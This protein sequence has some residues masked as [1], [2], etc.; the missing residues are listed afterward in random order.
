MLYVIKFKL[1]HYCFWT[2]LLCYMLTGSDLFAIN[3]VLENPCRYEDQEVEV[4]GF[5]YQS[6]AGDL[7]LRAESGLKSCCVHTGVL[8]DRQIII[9]SPDKL[10]LST[11]VVALVGT[12]KIDKTHDAQGRL[13]QTF[14]LENAHQKEQRK[15]PLVLIGI[16]SISLLGAAFLFF[17]RKYS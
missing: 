2:L 12:F 16:V 11:S 10:A 13:I 8:G 4:R 6:M 1:P 15:M 3:E 7:V 14:V 9:K 5:L 17:R